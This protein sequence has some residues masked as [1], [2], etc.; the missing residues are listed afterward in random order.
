MGWLRFGCS[1][2][3][4]QPSKAAFE[5]FESANAKFLEVA[6]NSDVAWRA[7]GDWYTQAAAVVDR[8][9]TRLA[10]DALDK[11]VAAYREAVRLYPNDAMCRGLL[12]ESELAA[13]NRAAFRREA[14]IALQLDRITPHANKKLPEDMRRTALAPD[15][16]AVTPHH[17]VPTLCVG[18]RV[19]QTLRV[20]PDD[21]ER[22]RRC[23]PTR[24]VG[25]RGRVFDLAVVQETRLR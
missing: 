17:L 25:T 3:G 13:G 19:F 23:V 22:R 2:G 16:E 24:S 4:R 9:G 5:R 11:A 10:S 6:P 7:S 1:S 8:H 15:G 21:A 18:T 20:K 12:A 14:E